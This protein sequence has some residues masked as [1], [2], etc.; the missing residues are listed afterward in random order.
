M[1]KGFSLIEILIVVA[2]LGILAAIVVPTFQNNAKQAAEAAIK[3]NLRLMR[4]TI[5]L[6]AAKNNDVPPGYPFNDTSRAP[7]R[8]AFIYQIMADPAPYL[9]ALP[10]NPF[11]EK[12]SI[13]MI[14]DG[15]DMPT[16]ATGVYG[17]I[18]K[19]ATKDIQLDWPGTDDNGIRYYDY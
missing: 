17:W 7:N 2:I 8:A 9:N 16:E 11:N 19:P 18:Y 1:K 13:Q 3:S 4:S 6:Y 15:S 10:Y 14:N 5:E 12:I